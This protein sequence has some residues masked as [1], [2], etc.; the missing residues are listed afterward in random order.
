MRERVWDRRIDLFI[1][2]ALVAAAAWGWGPGLTWGLPAAGVD[3][4]L[5]GT[6]TPWTGAEVQSLA[7]G[8]AH[9]VDAAAEQFRARIVRR[10]RLD[11]P[12]AA[13][14]RAAADIAGWT[15]ARPS[16]N[17]VPVKLALWAVALSRGEAAVLTPA[18]YLDRPDRVRR[19]YVAGRLWSMAWGVA[20][21]VAVYLILKR[22]IARPAAAG[23]GVGLILCPWLIVA[24]HAAGP[25]VPAVGA[26]LVIAAAAI[27]GRL[28]RTPQAAGW[29]VAA[30]AGVAVLLVLP[31]GVRYR[32]AYQT[33]AGPGAARFE[34]A[35]LIDH[36][37]GA[38]LLCPEFPDAPGPAALPPVDLWRWTFANGPAGGNR[39]GPPDVV[40]RPVKVGADATQ[41]PDGRLRLA[42][43]T[44]HV[45]FAAPL[46]PA[47]QPFEVIAKSYRRR[48]P[49]D[50]ATRPTTEPAEPIDVESP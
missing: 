8:P 6:R 29:S 11:S 32:Y 5:F 22:L 1:A 46:T 21:V 16:L 33:A 24:V 25:G 3:R 31:F 15:D 44:R 42:N 41:R 2:A 30:A 48:L 39:T 47:D 4:A 17:V 34:A 37:G 20:G 35:D 49:Q 27:V 50:A 26:V 36:A 40:V 45:W 13:E 18:E 12:D 28:K 9:S 14:S 7:D 19:V 23:A 43:G 10:F 38:T